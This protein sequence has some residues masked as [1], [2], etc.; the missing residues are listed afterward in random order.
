MSKERLDKLWLSYTNDL[1]SRK[2]MTAKEIH[3]A[4]RWSVHDVIGRLEQEYGSNPRAEFIVLT[5]LDDEGNSNF[6]YGYGGGFD[7]KYFEL[8]D[9]SEAEVLIGEP[10]VEQASIG[11]KVYNLEF[12]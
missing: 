7:T 6:N 9:R 5:A 3:N 4:T 11:K 2:K 12:I 1:K 10:T 8:P